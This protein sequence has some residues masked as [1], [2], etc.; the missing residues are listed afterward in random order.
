MV[1]R[2]WYDPP[3][4]SSNYARARAPF[5]AMAASLGW[6]TIIAPDGHS[7]SHHWHVTKEGL[8]A[9]QNRNIMEGRR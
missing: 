8:T 9:L 1:D 7:L 2:V 5:I 3:S 4:I 6:I